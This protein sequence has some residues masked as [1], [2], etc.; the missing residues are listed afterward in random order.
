MNVTNYALPYQQQQL[1]TKPERER[2]YKIGLMLAVS[3]VIITQVPIANKGDDNQT[4]ILN[5]SAS[6]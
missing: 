2:E 1:R 3:H 6:S 5:I 4:L